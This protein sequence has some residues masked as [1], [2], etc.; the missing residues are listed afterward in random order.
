VDVEIAGV[1]HHVGLGLERLEHLPFAFDA[2]L[3]GCFADRMPASRALVAAHEHIS[4]RIEEQDTD[5]LGGRAQRIDGRPDLLLVVAAADDERRPIV[6][7]SWICHQFREL[8][9]QNGRHVVDHEP[10]EIFQMIRCLRAARPRQPRDHHEIAHDWTPKYRCDVV[11]DG[12][13]N[14]QRAPGAA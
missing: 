13:V 5:P 1:E 9:D 14:R 3:E 6:G 12:F 11:I 4:R 10:A 8:W 2:L 7:A